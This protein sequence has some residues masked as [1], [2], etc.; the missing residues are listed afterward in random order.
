MHLFDLIQTGYFWGVFGAST[1]VLVVLR[2]AA[3]R[4]ARRPYCYHRALRK[5]FIRPPGIFGLSVGDNRLLMTGTPRARFFNPVAFCEFLGAEPSLVLWYVGGWFVLFADWQ[6]V[7]W[8]MGAAF[9][10]RLGWDHRDGPVRSGAPD[11]RTERTLVHSIWAASSG[12]YFA[13]ITAVIVVVFIFAIALVCMAAS[14]RGSG[15][16]RRR[17]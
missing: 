12:I 13:A 14:R 17:F 1:L 11:V 8:W 16:R 7:A 3:G 6:H 15:L 9:L 4:E 2:V 10:W 5:N